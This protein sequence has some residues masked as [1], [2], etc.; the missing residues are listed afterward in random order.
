MVLESNFDGGNNRAAS[1]R[2]LLTIKEVAQ[3]LGCSEANV[4][5]LITSGELPFIQIGIRKGYRVDS[6][7]LDAFLERRK[8]QSE[9]PAPRKVPTPR[10]K[11]IR[12][13]GP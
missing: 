13:A 5:A 7:D 12:L 4:Y 2:R 9:T 8:T 10:L 3:F 11:H 6:W 1:D